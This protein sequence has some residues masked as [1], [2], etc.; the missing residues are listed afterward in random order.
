MSRMMDEF[1]KEL[2][3]V[4]IKG[5]MQGQEVLLEKLEETY[6]HCDLLEELWITAED[7]RQ[8][9]SFCE[10]YYAINHGTIHTNRDEEWLECL[11]YYNRQI[12]ILWVQYM[13]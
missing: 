5:F 12:E 6:S 7:L 9:N 4:K 2:K 11:D 10:L 13:Q 1:N 3:E 8:C